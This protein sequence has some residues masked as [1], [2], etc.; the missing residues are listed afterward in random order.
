MYNFRTVLCSLCF[1][2]RQITKFLY[3]LRMLRLLYFCI[4]SWATEAS[5]P[6][7]SA[8]TDCP[9]DTL[10]LHFFTG[11]RWRVSLCP[12]LSEKNPRDWAE[13]SCLRLHW[14]W[15]PRWKKLWQV[16]PAFSCVS[17]LAVCNCLESGGWG[18]GWGKHVRCKGKSV[19]VAPRIQSEHIRLEI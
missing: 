17:Y 4:Q 9:D 1:M 11:S 3:L 12:S 15:G 2:E 13:N 8:V 14:Q 16:R 7:C 6:D 10:S 5:R 19:E 18:G